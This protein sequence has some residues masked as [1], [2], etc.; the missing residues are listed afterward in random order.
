M[1]NCSF[2]EVVVKVREVFG[3]GQIGLGIPLF[4]KELEKADDIVR[5]IVQTN[6]SIFK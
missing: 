1:C 6:L 5:I 3:L 2:S 4:Y